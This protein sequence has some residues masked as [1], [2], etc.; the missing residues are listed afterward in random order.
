[1][2]HYKINLLLTKLF[3]LEFHHTLTFL[4]LP[5]DKNNDEIKENSTRV[6]KSTE[7]EM[8]SDTLMAK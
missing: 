4:T 1:M 8:H 7:P 6:L 5:I 2:L 3:F